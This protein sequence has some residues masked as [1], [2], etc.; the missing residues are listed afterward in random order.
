M[1]PTNRQQSGFVLVLTLIVV[2]VVVSIGMTLLDLTIKQLRL[3]TGS[4]DSESAFHAASAGVE[5]IRYWRLASSTEFEEGGGSLVPIACFGQP[6]VN[7]TEI[8]IAGVGTEDIYQYEFQIS[9]GDAAAPRCSEI[10]MITLSS[11]PTSSGVTLTGIPALIP[12]YPASDKVCQPG[13]RCTIVSAK[14]Y[15]K[16]CAT[17]SQVGSVQ[18][19][20]LLEL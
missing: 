16:S 17:I 8:P 5:C 19:E 20:V 3:G 2:S 11:D 1:L 12:G 13:G 6:A 9:W 7:P 10:T 15:N 18:R 4:K 14:G